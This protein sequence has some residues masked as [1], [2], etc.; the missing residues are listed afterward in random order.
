MPPRPLDVALHEAA[1]VVVGV[2]LGLRLR[3]V[4][5]ESRPGWTWGGYA[6][7]P[8]GHKH[9]LA[10][11][12]AAGVAWDRA[13]VAPEWRKAEDVRLVRELAPGR[14]GLEACVR[15]AGAML[16]GLGV[17]HARVTRALLEQDLRGADIAALA[18][19]ERLTFDE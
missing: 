7:F 3:C 16:A 5:L 6:W 8:K 19:G 17:A 1:H 15:G 12:Y 9:A 11:M 4:V 14:G 18:R 10:L 13:M 2:A